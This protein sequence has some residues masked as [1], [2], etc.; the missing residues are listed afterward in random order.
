MKIINS[1]LRVS[2]ALLIITPILGAFGIF[3]EPTSDLYNTPE[4]Y[5]FIKM[6]YDAG[7]I[8]YI[9]AAVFATAIVLTALNRMA[10]VALLI[11]PI[12]VNIIGFHMFLDGGLFTTGAIMANVLLLLNVYFLWQNCTAY[13]GFWNTNSDQ[14]K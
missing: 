4:A 10:V 13:Q 5:A 11:L 1:I 7:Y 2:L 8:L 9:M 3:P 12:T 6:L 14:I